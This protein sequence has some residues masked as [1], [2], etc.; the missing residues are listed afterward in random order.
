MQ[1]NLHQWNKVSVLKTP[2]AINIRLQINQ[3]VILVM[4]DLNDQ[5]IND[6]LVDLPG[7]A[8]VSLISNR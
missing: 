7:P 8:D 4:R 5:L 1:M 2:L 6:S 3:K